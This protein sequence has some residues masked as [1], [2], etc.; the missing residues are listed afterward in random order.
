MP[1]QARHDVFVFISHCALDA[2]SGMGLRV[3]FVYILTNYKQTVLYTGV[4]NDLERRMHEH[5]SKFNSN[6]FTARYNIDRLVWYETHRWIHEAIHREKLIKKWKRAWKV[7]L[8]NEF[9]PDWQ[10]LSADW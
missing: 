8:V 6:S 1:C 2:Q 7:E 10:D 4:S 9:N 3:Y 5:K